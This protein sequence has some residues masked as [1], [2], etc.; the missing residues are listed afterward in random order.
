MGEV[1]E[2]VL[3]EC[4]ER[5]KVCCGVGE[6]R[7][8]VWGKVTRD[9]GGVKKCGGMSGRVFGVTVEGVLGCEVELGSATWKTVGVGR[10]W[11]HNPE[12]PYPNSP[13]PNSADTDSPDPNSSVGRKKC[14]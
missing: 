12:P 14:K 9:V 8:E 5:G 4:A 13:D 10:G 6:V 7:K 3:G 1:W 2:S 11:C